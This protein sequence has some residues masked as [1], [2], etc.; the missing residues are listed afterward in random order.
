MDIFL[1]IRNLFVYKLNVMY[2]EIEENGCTLN[3][4]DL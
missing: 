2:V 3:K 1:I 4:Y